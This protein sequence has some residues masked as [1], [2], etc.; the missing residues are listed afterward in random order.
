MPGLDEICRGFPL[1]G[2][3]QQLHVFQTEILAGVSILLDSEDLTR[4]SK[5]VLGRRFDLKSAYRQF[6]V[7]TQHAQKLRI[8]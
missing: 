5:G 7:D 1:T 4:L 8:Q 6:V 2:W 3:D